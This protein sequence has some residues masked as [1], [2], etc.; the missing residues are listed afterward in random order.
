MNAVKHIN[1]YLLNRDYN[2]AINN[3]KERMS[4]DE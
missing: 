3:F 2:K 1:S 4:V